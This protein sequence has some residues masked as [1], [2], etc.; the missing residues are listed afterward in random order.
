MQNTL[1]SIVGPT[2]TGK[3]QLALNLGNLFWQKFNKTVNIV[4]ADS[5]QVYQELPILTGADIPVDFALTT[6]KNL[7]PLWQDTNQHINLHGIGIIKCNEEWSV[8]HFQ[9]FAQNI[10]NHSWQTQ[11][12]PIIVGGTGLYHNHLFNADYQLKIK[13]NIEVRQKAEQ[14]IL[15]ELQNWLKKINQQ[16]W[17]SMNQSDKANP[18]RLIRAIE[19]SLAKPK[20][21]FKKTTASFKNLTIGLKLPLEKIK[22]KIHQRV[23]K[24]WQN[25][26]QDEVKKLIKNNH[27]A[28]FLHS[29]TGVKE[30]TNFL[31]GQITKTQCLTNWAKAEIAYA[32]RQLTW[33]KKRKNITWFNANDHQLV[34]NTWQLLQQKFSL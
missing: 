29:A 12:M 26:V 20:K 30:I 15:S 33:W 27:K 9:N 2:A 16:K 32:K 18:R 10:I 23:A 14:M 21:Q 4:S 13:P 6:K 28:H 25:G 3:T 24:R 1:L 7:Y 34:N 22:A 5:R 8:S 17:Q 19:I 31:N 11:S